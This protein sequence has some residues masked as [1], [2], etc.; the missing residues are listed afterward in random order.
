MPDWKKL[1]IIGM[2]VLLPGCAG[3]DAFERLIYTGG[4]GFPAGDA[5]RWQPCLPEDAAGLT[6]GDALL[7]QVCRRALADAGLTGDTLPV[8]LVMLSGVEN[9]DPEG[10]ARLSGEPA[11]LNPARAASLLRLAGPVHDLTADADALGAAL[12]KAQ[13]FLANPAVAAVVVAGAAALAHVPPAE[14]PHSLGFDETIATWRAGEGAAALVLTRQLT[15]G[16]RVYAC[17]DALADSPAAALAAAGAQPQQIGYLEAFACGVDYLDAVEAGELT[18]AYPAGSEPTTALG[19]LQANCGHLFAAAGVAALARAALCL[20]HRI[21]PAAPNWRAPKDAALWQRS[22]FFVPTEGRAWFHDQPGEPRRAAVSYITPQGRLQHALLS[23]DLRQTV[24]PS[25]AVQLEPHCFLPL[26]AENSADL[27]PALAALQTELA[28]MTQVQPLAKRRLAEWQPAPFNLI[29]LGQ[30]PAE[31]QREV[32]LALRGIPRA[33]ENGSEWQTPQGSYF[34]P[35][36]LHED[37]KIAFIFPGGFNSYVGIARDLFYLFPEL[38]ERSRAISE[39]IGYMLRARSLYPRRLTALT[40]AEQTA[41]EAALIADPI[42]MTASGT[43]LAYLYTLVLR[44]IFG[45]Q[46]QIMFGYSQGENSMLY[47]SGLWVNGEENIRQ[48]EQS[49]LFRTRLAGPQNAVRQ[50]W[51]LPQMPDDFRNEDGFYTNYILMANPDAVR[52]AVEQEKRVY[53]THINTPRQVV[54]G[55]EQ[56]GCQRVIAAVRCNSLRAP[57]NYALHCPPMRLELAELERLHTRPISAMPQARLFTAATYDEVKYDPQSVAQGAAE[58]LSA[59]LDFPRLVNRV[60][61]EG[62]RIFLEVGAGSNCAKWIDDTL[63]ERPH[64]SISV[65]RQGADDLTSILRLLARLVSHGAPVNLRP[66]LGG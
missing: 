47:A 58:A 55:G 56:A 48:L 45:V 8:G 28:G 61:D 6:V 62:I 4:Q 34:T 66:L 51:G 27:L 33:L 29:L 2:D 57:F 65:N 3:L 63:K 5:A 15:G 64:L 43:A 59:P 31:V 36:P 42:S 41:V 7:L 24:R 50:H 60:Y 35:R 21:L 37:G 17:L 49:P 14:T 26:S 13:A 11:R 1:A 52:T 22:A 30:T 53:L 20:Y 12:E 38:Y 16:R 25:V 54:I 23:E 19:S 46:P 9:F 39:R 44:D 18:A 10:T 32:E 40:K